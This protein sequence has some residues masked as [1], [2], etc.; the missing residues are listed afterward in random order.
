MYLI[1]YLAKNGRKGFKI[2]HN[3]ILTWINQLK[4]MGC[5]LP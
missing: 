4:L 2:S 3:I 1:C 5:G